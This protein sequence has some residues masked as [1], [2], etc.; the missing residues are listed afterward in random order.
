MLSDAAEPNVAKKCKLPLA[1]TVAE[2]P[3]DIEIQGFENCAVVPLTAYVLPPT[4]GIELKSNNGA[5]RDQ[6]APAFVVL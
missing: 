5:K 6:L 3:S 2:E 1:S 4:D